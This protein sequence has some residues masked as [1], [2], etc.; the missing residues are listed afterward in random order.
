MIPENIESLIYRNLDLTIMKI[1][2]GKNV[3]SFKAELEGDLNG[4][5]M[6]ITGYGLTIVESIKNLS[7]EINKENINL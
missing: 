2:G 5:F 4:E 1:H 6:L 7:L 3:G